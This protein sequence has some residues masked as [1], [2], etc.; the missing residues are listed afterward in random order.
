MS[1]DTLLMTIDCKIISLDKDTPIVRLTPPPACHL[2]T[3]VGGAFMVLTWFLRFLSVP[4][5]T[6]QLDVTFPSCHYR[7][8]SSSQTLSSLFVLLYTREEVYSLFH[9]SK[10]ADCKWTDCQNTSGAVASALRTIPSGLSDARS[11]EVIDDSNQPCAAC[12]GSD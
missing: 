3:K 4:P 5:P 10:C 6:F 11:A 7:S 9:G 2:L 8:V 1:L 12:Y